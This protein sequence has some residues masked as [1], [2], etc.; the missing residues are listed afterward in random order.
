MFRRRGRSFSRFRARFKRRRRSLY[1][2]QGG[3]WQRCQFN[4]PTSL[5][6]GGG[7]SYVDWNSL[8]SIVR[9]LNDPSTA[10][11]VVMTQIA[12]YIEVRAIQWDHTFS[13][14]VPPIVAQQAVTAVDW[15]FGGFCVERLDANGSPVSGG[16]F[17][18]FT[19]ESPVEDYP[20][21]PALTQTNIS[22]PLRWLRTK[23]QHFQSGNL[24]NVSTTFVNGS[25]QARWSARYSRPIRL[26]DTTGLWWV[27]GRNTLLD[28]ETGSSVYSILSGALWYRVGFGR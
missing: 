19:T 28:V 17:D 9:H 23:Y 3:R 18:P 8:L 6:G 21:N 27:V 24:N 14:W 26:D 13:Y 16:L 25:S 12:R 11:G 1:P 5:L 22:S 4:I 2:H 10:D 7:A 15:L 20:P